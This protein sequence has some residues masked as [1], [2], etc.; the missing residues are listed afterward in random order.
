[1]LILGALLGLFQGCKPAPEPVAP[2]G[3]IAVQIPV[4]VGEEDNSHYELKTVT[5]MGIASLREVRGVFAQFFYAP[6]LVEN[7][8]NGD[9]PIAYFAKTKDQVFVPKDQRSLQMATLYYHMQ[10][11]ITAAQDLGITTKAPFQVGVNTRVKG[12]E[13]LASNNAFYDG[14]SKAMLFV[15]YTASELPISVN[16]G[17]VAHEFFHSI[18]YSKVLAP[19]SQRKTSVSQKLSDLNVH[20]FESSS[21]ETIDVVLTEPELFNET[22]LRGI[23]EGLAD[24]WGWAYT[25]DPDFLKWSLSKHKERRTLKKQSKAYYQ[26]QDDIKKTINEV[27]GSTQN[28]SQALTNYI[29]EVGTPY[30]RFLKELVHIKVRNNGLSLSEAKKYV[31]Q[32]VIDFVDSVRISSLGLK[33]KDRLSVEALF[34]TVAQKDEKQQSLEQ[35]ELIIEYLN[36]S[37]AEFKCKKQDDSENYKVDVE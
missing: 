27:K 8:L 14:R 35:C 31:S 17:I 36:S 22:Y 15:P 29:Y 6:G 20:S 19:L 1:M 37:G 5:L 3:N 28:T 13:A 32:L 21:R 24:F 25:N 18:F 7:R 2:Q 16:A 11:L 10:N 4:V 34:F 9:S 26:T 12:D 23:N 30:A 33:P